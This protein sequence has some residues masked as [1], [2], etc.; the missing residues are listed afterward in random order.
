MDILAV[1]TGAFIF[2]AGVLAG[3]FLYYRAESRQPPL[4]A[5]KPAAKHKVRPAARDEDID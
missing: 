3:A 4:P 5:V 2:S 1:F